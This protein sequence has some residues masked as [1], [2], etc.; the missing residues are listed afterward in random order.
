V[1]VACVVYLLFLCKYGAFGSMR[2]SYLCNPDTTGSYCPFFVLKEKGKHVQSF[3]DANLIRVALKC[4][5]T[6][7]LACLYR[8]TFG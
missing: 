5:D 8:G 6:G 1:V 7:G 4:R 2:T 3:L